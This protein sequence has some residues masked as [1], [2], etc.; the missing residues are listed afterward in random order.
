MQNY[1]NNYRKFFG[2]DVMDFIHNQLSEKEIVSSG[3]KIHLDIFERAKDAP[4][5]VF[6]HGMAGYGRLLA[7][8][9]YRL[10]NQGY[11]VVLP[12]LT[13][14]GHNKGL[15]GHWIWKDLVNNIIDTCVF[16]KESYNEKV[17]LAGG[18][19]GG[20]I[21][22]HA[23]CHNA[24]V[25]ALASYCLFDFQDK[26]LVRE[27]SSYGIFTPI[28]KNSLK[29]FAKVFPNIRIPATKVSSYDNLS[30]NKEFNNLVKSDPLGGNKMSLKAASELLSVRL[31]IRFEDFT[32]VPV[33]VIQPSADKMTPAKFSYKAYETL[34]I[35]DKKYVNLPDRG[36][37]VLDDE[38]ID[39]ICNEMDEWFRNK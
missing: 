18:S 37:W 5:I 29:L 28:I 2:E 9:A 25:K 38:G 15:R 26:E 27:T 22:Y 24:P 10:Y 19:M 21:A 14:Y 34:G 7:P 1:F 30:D 36:H 13:G 23:V 11:N 32:K 17:Y 4:T 20:C 8:Y 33:L 6:S 3:N 39:I 31:P 16:A 12:D 35:K